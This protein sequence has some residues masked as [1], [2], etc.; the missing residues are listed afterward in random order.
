MLQL[1]NELGPKWGQ[2]AQRIPGRT[3]RQIRVRAA[4]LAREQQEQ[5][6][7]ATDA[8]SAE[9]ATAAPSQAWEAVRPPPHVHRVSTLFLRYHHQ[10]LLSAVSMRLRLQLG[11]CWE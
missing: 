4:T 3:K 7:A 9:R 5:Q 11:L 2:L 6:V 1:Y 10:S 8:A